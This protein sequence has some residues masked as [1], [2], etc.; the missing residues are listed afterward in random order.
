[1][2]E[3]CFIVRRG[4]DLTVPNDHATDL[5]GSWSFLPDSSLFY[6]ER[7]ELLIFRPSPVARPRANI[8]LSVMNDIWHCRSYTAVRH[9]RKGTLPVRNPSSPVELAEAIGLREVGPAHIQNSSELY[10]GSLPMPKLMQDSKTVV[11][12]N[13][14]RRGR[15]SHPP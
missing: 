9:R 7:H 4:Q 14:V 1:V 10:N 2:A 13:C 6:R 12:S 15:E 5:A 11:E 3:L 8:I